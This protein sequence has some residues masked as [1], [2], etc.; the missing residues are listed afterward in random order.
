M[1]T[2]VERYDEAIA[3]VE[4][5]KNDEALQ[6]MESLAADEP[7][8]ALAHAALTV[9]YGKLERFDEGIA[10]A[11]KVCELEPNDPFSFVAKSLICQKAGKLSD[12][13]EAM[14]KA[15]QVEFI[16]MQAARRAEAQGEQ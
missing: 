1:P 16:A 2:R 9:F 4:Q 11:E 5:G 13:E 7:D 15:R 3:L 14:A 8:Y 12:A 10:Q 6:K